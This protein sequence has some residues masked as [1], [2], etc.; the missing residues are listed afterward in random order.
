MCIHE[1]E[2]L[3]RKNIMGSLEA[4]HI[5]DIV[6]DL[7]MGILAG[8][9]TANL[10]VLNKSSFQNH[11]RHPGIHWDKVG[12]EWARAANPEGDSA[13]Q[14]WARGCWAAVGSGPG[15]E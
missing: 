6:A 8:K 7:A 14:G 9:Q 1:L 4:I 5:P 13:V 15:Q 3:S 10:V 12:V 2:H 11:C